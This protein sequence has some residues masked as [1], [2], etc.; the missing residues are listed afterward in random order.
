MLECLKQKKKF[1][2][3]I[4]CELQ[5]GNTNRIWRF[6]RTMANTKYD[7]KVVMCMRNKSETIPCGK[8]NKNNTAT[9]GVFCVFGSWWILNE[10]WRAYC[11][12]GNSSAG[13]RYQSK[14]KIDKNTVG[15]AHRLHQSWP[16]HRVELN[17]IKCQFIRIIDEFLIRSNVAAQHIHMRCDAIRYSIY[18][19]QT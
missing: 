18:V 15:W 6:D 19:G 1:A 11:P 13:N 14:G 16:S 10:I 4:K 7:D 17:G 9:G 8:S 2:F 3:S 12:N 5:L